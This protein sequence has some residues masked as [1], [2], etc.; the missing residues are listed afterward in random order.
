MPIKLFNKKKVTDITSEQPVSVGFEYD[1]ENDALILQIHNHHTDESI[2][3]LFDK[4]EMTK[5]HQYL[6]E[7]LNES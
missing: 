2:R 3:A 4:K 7:L 1:K 5:L 6:G